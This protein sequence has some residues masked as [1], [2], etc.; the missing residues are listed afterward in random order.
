MD[1]SVTLLL[2]L[3]DGENVNKPIIEGK[4]DHW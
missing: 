1:P 4:Q 2:K 3:E